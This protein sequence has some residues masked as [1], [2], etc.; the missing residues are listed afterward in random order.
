M[1]K[2]FLLLILL[3]L[4]L[5]A[6]AETLQLPPGDSAATVPLV[7]PERGQTMAAVERRFGSPTHRRGP[8]GGDTEFQPPITRWDYRNFY[9]VFEHDRVIDA[10]VPDAPPKL[11][12]RDQLQPAG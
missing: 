7:L 1:E 12:H 6:G 4:P 5:A 10:V 8:V 3:C 9:V 11:H 2:K